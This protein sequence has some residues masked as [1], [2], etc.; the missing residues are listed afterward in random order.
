MKRILL[1]LALSA[2]TFCGYTQKKDWAQFGRYEKANKEVLATG[3]RPDAVFMGNTL[4][5]VFFFCCP[6]RFE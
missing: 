5:G 4:Q 1:I 6:R 2:V 3:V